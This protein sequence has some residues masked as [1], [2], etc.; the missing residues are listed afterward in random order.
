[1]A[2]ASCGGQR[3]DGSE[4]IVGPGIMNLT[5]AIRRFASDEDLDRFL[6]RNS[7]Q[8]RHVVRDGDTLVVPPFTRS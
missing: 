3:G 1:M 5:G 6:A 8:V 4:R 2:C 7:S